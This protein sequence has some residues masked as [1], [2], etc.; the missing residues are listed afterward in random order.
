MQS[1]DLVMLFPSLN[2][3]ILHV[4][5]SVEQVVGNI[6]Y[7]DPVQGELLVEFMR[8]PPEGELLVLETARHFGNS[9]K[10]TAFHYA[11]I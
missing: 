4:V 7:V 9:D 5:D 1:F 11:F 8:L 2:L 6:F 10:L 3:I